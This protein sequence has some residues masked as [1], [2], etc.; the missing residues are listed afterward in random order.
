MKNYLTMSRCHGSITFTIYSILMKIFTMYQCF[1]NFFI[2]E[3]LLSKCSKGNHSG[4]VCAYW[5]R[6]GGTVS[7]SCDTLRVGVVQHFIKVTVEINGSSQEKREVPHMFAF[8]YWP[9]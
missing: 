5:P 8:V 7:P 1:M 6:T 4:V 9:S 2:G 3:R